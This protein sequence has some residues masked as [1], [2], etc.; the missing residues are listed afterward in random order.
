MDRIDAI[1]DASEFLARILARYANIEAHYRDAKIPN[2]EHFEDGIVSI[3]VAV[4][5]YSARVKASQRA[6]RTSMVGSQK[7]KDIADVSRTRRRDPD[8]IDWA[9][10]PTFQRSHQ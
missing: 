4:L 5:Q 6:G 2:Q 9:A 8:F 3:Y 1:F 10:S 7:W